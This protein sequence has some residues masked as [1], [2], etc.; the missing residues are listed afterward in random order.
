MADQETPKPDA[1]DAAKFRQEMIDIQNQAAKQ[2]TDNIMS[3]I[4]TKLASAKPEPK[5]EPDEELSPDFQDYEDEIKQLDLDEIQSRA[6]LSMM[7]KLVA[8]K[9][10]GLKNEVKGEIKQTEEFKAKKQEYEAEVA[11]LYPDILKND[12]PLFRQAQVEWKNFDKAM[13]GSPMATYTAVE[14]AARK[15]GMSPVT[16]EDLKRRESQ[17]EGAGGSGDG[18]RDEKPTK[19]SLEFAEA[20]GVKGDKFEEKLKIVKA[21]RVG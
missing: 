14:R 12:S 18:R 9:T 13:L 20:F 21:A 6:I 3:Q 10:S 5:E 7:G 4:D 1:F 8:K 17:N 11:G 19:K 15:L 16:L 2:I